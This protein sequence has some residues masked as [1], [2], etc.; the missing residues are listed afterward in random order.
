MII[1][2]IPMIYLMSCLC[3]VCLMEIKA[4]FNTIPVISWRWVLLVEET[5]E[6]EKTTDLPQVTD[7]LY[8]IML[9]T[10]SWSRFELTTSVVI[11]T[12]CICSCKSNSYTITATT[13]LAIVRVV[14]LQF[15]TFVLVCL[16]SNLLQLTL[17]GVIYI[18]I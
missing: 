14:D 5:G 10:T 17:K 1:F 4:T 13:T 7:K 3:S 15:F 6:P 16:N 11:G 12:D 18:I 8:H 2:I 9:Y